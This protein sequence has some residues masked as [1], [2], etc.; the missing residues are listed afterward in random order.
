MIEIG[1]RIAT[2]PS[3]A[4]NL[5]ALSALPSRLSRYRAGGSWQ[6]FPQFPLAIWVL[7]IAA[8]KP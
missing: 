2:D 4:D 3:A 6:G 7:P 8:A 1:A 5:S